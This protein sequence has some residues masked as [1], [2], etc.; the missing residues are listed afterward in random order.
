V[1]V[2]AELSLVPLY[3]DGPL[4]RE[5]IDYLVARGFHLVSLEGITEEPD[6]GHML[7][8]DGVFIRSEPATS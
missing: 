7:Q 3:R 2:E 5:V 4:Y 1:A 6:T 8:L